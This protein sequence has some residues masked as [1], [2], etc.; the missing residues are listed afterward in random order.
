MKSNFMRNAKKKNADEVLSFRDVFWKYRDAALMKLNLSYEKQRE[1]I[2]KAVLMNN[3]LDDIRSVHWHKKLKVIHYIGQL[4]P[5]GSERQL[6]YLATTLYKRG[7]DTSVLV[8]KMIEGDTGHY[9]P[10]FIQGN[11]PV[12]TIWSGSNRAS[13]SHR[14]ISHSIKTQSMLSKE[15]MKC[16]PVYISRYVYS[17]ANELIIKKPDVLH[18][19]LD[20]CNILGGLAGFIADVPLIILSG[21]SV[22]PTHFPWLNQPWFYDWYKVLCQSKRVVFLNNSK[23]GAQDYA[24]W[25][26]MSPNAIQVISNGLDFRQFNGVSL[27][28]VASFRNSIGI[29]DSV[30]LVAGIFRLT[31]EKRPLDFLAVIQFVQKTIRDLKVVIIGIGPLEN[32]IKKNIQEMGLENTVY[33]LGRRTDIPI[34]LKAIDAILQVSENEGSPNTLIEA[35]YM[36]V[37]VVTTQVGGTPE[38]VIDGVTA[39]LHA[40]GDIVGLANSLIRI[41]KDKQLGSKMGM[42]GHMFI[43]SH[44]S[45]DRMVNETLKLYGYQQEQEELHQL[46]KPLKI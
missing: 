20:F 34:I 37:P 21:R 43:S 46:D 18:C 14:I 42:N 26:D 23:A 6:C 4:G 19:W 35:Q 7:I 25:L 8:N 10:L 36:G 22:N 2:L 44:F 1:K 40:A 27:D 13:N 12:K 32:Q 17:L 9:V 39:F 45:I 11:V 3:T 29:S 5:G 28:K 30:P 24:K 16:I 15:A 31:P 41:L 33:L 38:V